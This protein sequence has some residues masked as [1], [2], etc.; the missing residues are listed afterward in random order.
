MSEARQALLAK[1]TDHVANHGLSDTSLRDLAEAV[2]TSHRMLIYHFGGR[3][4]LVAALVEAMQASQR[5][6]LDA[7]AGE[8]TSPTEIVAARWEELTRDEVL[9]FVKLF[10]EVLAHSLYGRPG[11]DGFLDGLTEP[12]ITTGSAI[13]DRLGLMIDVRDLRLGI[14]VIRGLLLDA[15]ASG[16]IDGARDSLD[17]FLAMWDQAGTGA[18]GKLDPES[19]GAGGTL[20]A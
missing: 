18:Q 14:A 7:L 12:W 16:D 13:A 2:G 4:G 9:P 17:R 3:P 19:T 10:F 6:V 11:T 8:A 1:I 5:V 15:V 20:L